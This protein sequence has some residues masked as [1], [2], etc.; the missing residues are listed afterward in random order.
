MNILIVEDDY[1][2]FDWI[3]M[4]LK[5]AFNTEPDRIRTEGEFRSSL[6]DIKTSPPDVIIMDVMLPWEMSDENMVP[7]PDEVKQ[8]GEY[9]AGFRCQALLMKYEETKKIPVILYTV[10]NRED[11]RDELKE[12]P[13]NVMFMP[14]E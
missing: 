9:R 7:E 4:N 14:K 5:D 2:Q 3:N 12:L 6:E 11:L 10:Q 1:M 8:E 13:H